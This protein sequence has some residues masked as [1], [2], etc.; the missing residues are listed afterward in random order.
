M[1]TRR[2]KMSTRLA[3]S[4]TIAFL[5][6]L[7]ALSVGLGRIVLNELDNIGTIASERLT[8]NLAQVQISHLKLKEL[9]RL[10]HEGDDLHG[11]RLEFNIYY[12]RVTILRESPI[13]ADL[14]ANAE[15]S[16]LL[17]RIESRL[18]HFV[19][20]V[21][22]SDR[23][24][25]YSLPGFI[26]E[27][28]D[29]GHDVRD[30]VQHGLRLEGLTSA[31]KKQHLAL[32]MKRLAWV[33]LALVTAL[34]VT[35]LL[36][37]RL[38]HRGQMLS[39]TSEASAERMR[40]IVAS[41]LDAIILVDVRGRVMSFN[42]AAEA[43][44][45]YTSEEAI[46]RRLIDLIIPESQR[47][48]ARDNTASFLAAGESELVDHGRHQTESMRKSGEIFPV[49]MNVT[50]SKTGTDTVFVCFL[51]DITDRVKS[52][53]ALLQ[54]RDEALAGEKAKSKLLTVLGHEIRTPLNGIMGSIELLETTGMLAEEQ[55]YLRAMRVSGELLLH[56]VN[57]VLEMSRLEAG[58]ELEQSGPFDLQVL[59]QELVDRNHYAAQ[60]RENQIRLRCRL[61][62]QSYCLGN[63][64]RIRQ[65]LSR[66]IGN[67]LKF[68]ENGEITVEAERVGNNDTVEFRVCDTGKG[69]AAEDLERIFEGFVTLDSSYSRKSDGTG[70]GLA[71]TQGIVGQLGGELFVESELGEG[72]MFWFSISLPLLSVRQAQQPELATEVVAPKRL[73]VVEDNDINRMLLEKML[74]RQGHNVDCAA[75]GAE[76]VEAVANTKYD[77]VLMDISMPDV[78]GI[79][80]LKQIRL[81]KLAEGVE[82][83]ALTAHAA[84]D[85]Q[86]RIM[87]A[88]FT[89]VLTKPV[90][91]AELAAVIDRYIG[92]DALFDLGQGSSD[93]QQFVAALGEE[94][95]QGYL[96]DFCQ[97][98]ILLKQTLE[99]TG[100]VSEA[101]Q[102]EAHRL[103]GSA[104]V[105]GLDA[106]RACMVEIE[107]ALPNSELPLGTL[108]EAWSEADLI[109]APHLNG[110]QTRAQM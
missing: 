11:L 108:A 55:K 84:G 103:A 87:E 96:I 90:T 102:G 43:V 88:G 24:L 27:M 106:L 107:T 66:L 6:A 28:Q 100:R 33:L 101:Q 60:A 99:A 59:L 52:E 86:Q 64:Q 8:W 54:A 29:N 49:E 98:V 15:A 67:A 105:L 14:R 63:A 74:Q 57:E 104:A 69:I 32:T 35:A 2:A 51:R 41:S 48:F 97:D 73:L 85:D 36:I 62:V 76:G 7:A 1:Q 31:E 42:G 68:T 13:F 38:F 71:I 21:D 65:V 77:L 47:Q 92:E 80:A 16:V 79:E 46:G 19:P 37:W 18:N 82:I 23:G 94:K 5:A 12:S 109:L 89:E 95:A 72:S 10:S 75:G 83:V 22:G 58:V 44:Y 39:A 30:L 25:L 4:L 78:D 93:I 53:E 61:P 9:A 17:D 3:L 81:R 91:Q 56:H 40:A 34:G 26:L 70:L 50:S 110:I 45:G 20:I